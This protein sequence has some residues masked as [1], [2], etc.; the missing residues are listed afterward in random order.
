[1]DWARRVLGRPN[2]DGGDG[3]R[4]NSLRKFPERQYGVQRRILGQG[5]SC[6]VFLYEKCGEKSLFAVKTFTRSDLKD[7]DQ[8][9]MIEKE[10]LIHRLASHEKYT[11]KLIDAFTVKKKM[12]FFI[13]LEYMPCSLA[14]LYNT[15]KALLPQTDRLCYFKQIVEGVMY[16]QSKNIAHRDIKLEN[17]CIDT[18][19]NIKIIDF[20]SSTLG[21]LG[22]GMAGSP[23]YCA[24]EIQNSLSYNSFVSD[25]W[26][27]GIILVNLFYVSTTKW[28]T[29]HRNDRF[30]V[31]YLKEPIMKNVV[32]SLAGDLSSEF[33]S[34]QP[35]VDD[36]IL[37]LLTVDVTHRITLQQ[38]TQNELW[39]NEISCCTDTNHENGSPPLIHS[40]SLF[41]NRLSS[42]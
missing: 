36:I 10:L 29:A 12:D 5:S 16:L 25:V 32:N 8:I 13:V 39:F 17:C 15:Y 37:K 40:H 34:L 20:G 22:Y 2:K 19:G 33:V 11:V 21:N 7:E 23:I 30:Y 27:L 3:R 14:D 26:S 18:R 9:R 31:V 41:L 38:L 1:M 35:A 24:P 6:K 42:L 28:K 4:R